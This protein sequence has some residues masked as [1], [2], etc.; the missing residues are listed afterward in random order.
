MGH[1]IA[2][3]KKHQKKNMHCTAVIKLKYKIN[4]TFFS[5][6]TY[7]L[8][9]YLL[10]IRAARWVCVCA[11]DGQY[12]FFSTN[13]HYVYTN[14]TS[15]NS[16]LGIDLASSND[17]GYSW[18]WLKV[19]HK[20]THI[21]H[22]YLGYHKHKLHTQYFLKNIWP[23]QIMNYKCRKNTLET[24]ITLVHDIHFFFWI[25]NVTNHQSPMW[26]VYQ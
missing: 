10:Y 22:Y 14:F 23:C 2:T 17:T 5:H 20:Q 15:K 1:S 12:N 3:Q 9:R 11:S 21:A 16:L 25:W 26:K 19:M 13:A 8:I 4:V 6:L 7:D 18:Y 24:W